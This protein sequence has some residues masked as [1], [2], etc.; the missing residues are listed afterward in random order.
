MRAQTDIAQHAIHDDLVAH[1]E[2]THRQQA[3]DTPAPDRDRGFIEDR[4]QV[5][6]PLRQVLSYQPTEVLTGF[7]RD[8]ELKPTSGSLLVD[9]ILCL[10]F[11]RRCRYQPVPV[12]RRGDDRHIERR[13]APRR[14]SPPFRNFVSRSSSRAGSGGLPF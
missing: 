7:T 14:V 4:D 3:L 13:K 11:Q 8:A 6:G 2:R 12:P 9:Q 10:A 1:A 5:L